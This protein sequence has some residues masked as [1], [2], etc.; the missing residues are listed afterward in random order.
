MQNM[1]AMAFQNAGLQAIK[2]SYATAKQGVT[3]GA[4]SA[5]MELGAQGQQAQAANQQSAMNRGVYN[6]STF[7]MGARG[8]SSDL[9]R[10]LAMIDASTQQTLGQLD[11]G[12]GQATAQGYAGLAGLASNLSNQQTQLAGPMFGL[13]GDLFKAQ[14]QNHGLA[15]GLLG[16]AGAAI[17]AA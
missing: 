9:A 5:K 10:H 13:Y 16:L 6:T 8:I 1:K 15:G 3:S 4:S 12:Q 17:G 7:D 2:G 11:V 14:S